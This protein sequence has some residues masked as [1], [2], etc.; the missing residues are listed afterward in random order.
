MDELIRP[1][2]IEVAS[3]MMLGREASVAELAKVAR[4]STRAALE[5]AVARALARPPC[6]VSFS[7]GRDSSAVLALATAVARR[8]G[9]ADPIPAT[10]VYPNEPLTDETEWQLRV[11]DHLGLSEWARVTVNDELDLVGP[12]ALEVIERHGVL[13]PANAF[14]HVP[15]FRLAASG[16]LLSGAG[17]DEVLDS[18]AVALLRAVRGYERPSRNGLRAS[19]RE[20]GP[21]RTRHLGDEAVAGQPWLQPAARAEA[22][23]RA[24]E[25]IA[26]LGLRWDTGLRRWPADRYYLAVVGSLA[27]IGRD[28]DVEVIT[29]FLDLSVLVALAA[30][31]GWAG[32][33]SRADALRRLV[34]DLLPRP[35]LERKSKAVFTRAFRSEATTALVDNWDGVGVDPALVNVDTLRRVWKSDAPDARAA[36][37]LQQVAL[38]STRTV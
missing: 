33:A 23:R 17:G 32:F 25:A 16:S 5:R 19:A 38:A 27:A 24:G 3:G 8:D 2:R 26:A 14:A 10:L 9:Y 34:G 15:L 13:F 29:P 12:T 28:H 7:G 30:D 18:P 21:G 6:V 37:L 4:Q 36:L 11:V 35:I 1:D 22:S 31:G 20:L